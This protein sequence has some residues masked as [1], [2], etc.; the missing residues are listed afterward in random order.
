[1]WRNQPKKDVLFSHGHWASEFAG[2]PVYTK[3][4]FNVGVLL[5]A[6]ANDGV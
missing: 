3:I 2:G 5:L 1:M 4:A 6:L